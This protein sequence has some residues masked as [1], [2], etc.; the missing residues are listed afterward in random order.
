VL[1]SF[2][3]LG[4]A[5]E[6]YPSAA[7]WGNGSKPFRPK[8]PQVPGTVST[9]AQAGQIEPLLID[10]KSRCAVKEELIKPIGL[11]RPPCV[12]RALRRNHDEGKIGMLGHVRRQP[13][14]QDG[15]WIL[16]GLSKSMQEQDG[17]AFLVPAALQQ[18]GY[19]HQVIQ[20]KRLR[21]PQLPAQSLE[22]VIFGP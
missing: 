12:P 16:P 5:M 7:D 10:G 9:H 22:T 8:R 6:N 20:T 18:L 4:K 2:H 21:N 13:L 14:S 15:R 19:I 1:Q 3:S 11:L 17:W